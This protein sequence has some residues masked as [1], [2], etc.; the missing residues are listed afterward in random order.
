MKTSRR[1]F[2]KISSI[3][4]ASVPLVDMETKASFITPNLQ[5][6]KAKSVLE[7][8]FLH[9]PATVKSSCY[10]WWFNARVD[11]EGITRD[12]EEF[13]DKG[14]SEVVMIN[15]SGGLSGVPY[16]EGVPFLSEAWKE[17]Y[18]FAMKEAKRLDIGIGINLCSGWSM[19]GPWIKPENASRW[20][21]QSQIEVQGPKKFNEKL[22]LPNPRDR[23]D[24]VFNP[25]GFKDYIDLPIAQVD[26]QDT[27]IVAIPIT[28][29][30]N[31]KITGERAIVLPSKNNHKDATSWSRAS[32]SVGGT[33]YPWE[34][35][36][37]DRPIPVSA[38]ID[39]TDKVSKNGELNWEVPAG[40]WLIIRTGHRMTGSTVMVAQPEGA[41]LSVD[42][43][44]QKGV[45][46]QFE[47]LGKVFLEEAAKVGNKPKY[48]CDD[49][50][51]D[52]FP[53]WTSKILDYFKQYRGYD[54]LP[55]FPVLLG[56][57]VGSAEISDRFLHDYRKTLADCM[58]EHHYQHFADLCH[59]NGVLM[60]NESAGPSRSSTV[61][62]DGLKNLGKSDYPMGEFW[63]GTKH[64]QEGGLSEELSFGSTRIMGG[65][66]GQNI[67]CKMV[68]SASHIYGKKTASAE[69]FTSYRHW[70]D[71]PSNLKQ[72][73][74]RAFCEGINRIALHTS[75]ASRPSDGKPGYEY[76][77]GTHFNPN[78][79]WWERSTAFF[80]YVARC[81]YLLRA[82]KFVA[83]VLYYNGDNVPNLVDVK[84]INP[85]LGSGYDYDVCNEEVLLTR[86]SVKNGKIVL[87]DGMA[88]RI[89]VLPT[90]NRMPVAVLRKIKKL[91]TDGAT[92]LGIQPIKDTGL[93]NYPL[94]DQEIRK[95]GAELWGKADGK[96]VKLNHYGSGRVFCGIPE[97]AILMND[98]II[99]DFR[100]TGKENFIDFIHRTTNEAEIY[101]L[102]NRHKNIA[103]T[104]ATFRIKGRHPQL[105]DAVTGKILKT[106]NFTA[107]GNSVTVSLS[108]EPFQSVFVVFPK[109]EKE[110]QKSSGIRS[111]MQYQLEKI[112]ELTGDWQVQFDP[113]W[114]GPESVTFKA[115]S[116]WSKNPDE[117]IKYYS[118]KA[119][120]TK[121]FNLNGD[122]SA[123][124]QLFLALGVVRDIAHVKL[125]G[126]E[127]GTVWTSPWR[128]ALPKELLKST[129]N[130]L[131][132]EIINQWPNR[133]IGDVAL[134][135]EK[136]FTNTNI[137]FKSTDPLLPSG[138]LGP[139][140]LKGISY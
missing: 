121:E 75:T 2:I 138:L 36:P 119:F 125:N 139:V 44:D 61:S 48:F 63:L 120:Y 37:A 104:K 81:Q 65:A 50:F 15:S 47:N 92:I 140:I 22:P 89:L 66:D 68:A 4:A 27:A 38:V 52:G 33:I 13:K 113:K 16:P 51:E 134:P 88:Y 17:L 76:G 70:M 109:A 42:W 30:I 34:N 123:Y 59:G 128:I 86:L 6:I 79:T 20:Y 10:W 87:P 26:Y 117:R 132:I 94:C 122:Q 111:T 91:V 137:V 82:G 3:A 110:Q 116:D 112:A 101:F 99:P 78:V 83:D 29:E 49:S 1:K 105:W 90:T 84:K 56:Y 67:N 71:A 46:I 62:I 11:Q 40:K 55:Y 12:L 39:L 5:P 18:R 93:R 35:R 31:N 74:D 96:N 19:G 97:R 85:G 53:N 129:G 131:E 72:A 73:L 103:E 98:G 130:K 114:G 60:Q 41:G 9:P 25:P 80:D 14:I 58:A 100:F 57:N 127:L 64:D 23:Y 136:R 126:T 32:D 118:G 54:A 77:A 43:F 102:T 108:F 124:R 107:E 28:D 24:H 106:P 115:L 7:N 45:D 8:G 95:I 69:S 21:L 135:K 133:L